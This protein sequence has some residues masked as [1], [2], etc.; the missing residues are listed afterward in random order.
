MIA[1]VLPCSKVPQPEYVQPRGLQHSIGYLIH[2]KD[3]KST[4]EEQK[5]YY[6]Q[7]QD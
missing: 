7:M 1:V 6:L 2:N 4:E 3:Q 5:W